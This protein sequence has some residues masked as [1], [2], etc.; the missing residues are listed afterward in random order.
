MSFHFES[1]LAVGPHP[2]DIELGLGA[3]LHR[4]ATLNVPIRVIVF[5]SAAASLPP[6]VEERDIIREC[7]ASLEI[8]GVNHDN[9]EIHNFPVRRFDSYRQDIL[10]LLVTLDRAFSPEVVFCPSLSDTHQDHEVVSREC[11]RAFRKRTILGYE[12]PWNNRG[13]VP[14]VSL[15]VTRE[16]L[17]TKERALKCYAS[18]QGRQYFEPGLLSSLARLRASAAGVEFAESFDVTRMV[19]R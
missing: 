12:L 8:L 1:V 16:N 15:S 11:E 14:S 13:F 18:Q 3:S 4:L 2:D 19:I 5:S 10:E 7:Q 17:E 6:G 9:V